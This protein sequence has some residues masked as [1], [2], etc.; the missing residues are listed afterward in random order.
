MDNTLG[1]AYALAGAIYAGNTN[2]PTIQED[3]EDRI[4]SVVD[5]AGIPD[6]H[7]PHVYALMAEQLTATTPF[8]TAVEVIKEILDEVVAYG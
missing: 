5:N 7:K 3:T 4:Y 8:A 2:V 1:T 6:E